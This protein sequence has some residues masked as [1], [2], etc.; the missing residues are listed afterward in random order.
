MNMSITWYNEQPKDIVVTLTPLNLTMNKPGITYFD[1]AHQVMLGFDQENYKILIKP[2]TKTEA[3]RGD[4][5]EHTKYNITINSS[6]ARITN[7]SFM[8]HMNQ[9][10]D[11]QLTD[12]G[13]KYKAE[14][15]PSNRVLEVYLKEER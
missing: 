7:K 13:L 6:Y 9:L 11:L 8:S 4:I 5:P 3:I 1:N 14:W 10:F 12:K 2:L 15:I